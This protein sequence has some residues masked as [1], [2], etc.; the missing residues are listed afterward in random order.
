MNAHHPDP[1]PRSSSLRL[2]INRDATLTVVARGARIQRTSGISRYHDLASEVEVILAVARRIPDKRD[3]LSLADTL[4]T[5]RNTATLLL[6]NRE[7]VLNYGHQKALTEVSHAFL[8]FDCELQFDF[9]MRKVMRS[10]AE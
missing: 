7:R 6:L 2:P 5:R 8:V 4:H 3:A 10:A 9:P 1:N